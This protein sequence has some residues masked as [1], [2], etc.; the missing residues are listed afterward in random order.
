M[1][2][3]LINIAK[4]KNKSFFLQYSHGTGFLLIDNSHIANITDGDIQCVHSLFQ[5]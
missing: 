1:N 4:C 2:A 3:V 5:R